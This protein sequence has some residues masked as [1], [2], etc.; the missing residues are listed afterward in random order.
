ML[1]L[2]E[3]LVRGH[4]SGL[5]TVPDYNNLCQCENLEDIKLNL[6]CAGSRGGAK[7]SRA[8]TSSQRRCSSA[9][10]LLSSSRGC[11]RAWPALMHAQTATDYGPF[12]ANEA[13]PLYTTTLVERCTQKLVEDWHRMRCN[14]SA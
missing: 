7:A 8:Q 2:V 3:G 10:P 5:L 11:S 13:S 12:L 14:V 1:L 6:V 9:G 4:R